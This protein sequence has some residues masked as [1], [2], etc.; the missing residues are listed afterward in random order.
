MAVIIFF[1][2][3]DSRN[4]LVFEIIQLTVYKNIMIKWLRLTFVTS[5]T[6]DSL[7][8]YNVKTYIVNLLKNYRTE[9]PE[10]YSIVKVGTYILYNG[11]QT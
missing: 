8:L 6:P 1:T 4:R 10:I 5:Q 11:I 9:N 2:F 7:A 3:V